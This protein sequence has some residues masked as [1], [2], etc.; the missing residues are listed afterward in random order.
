MAAERADRPLVGAVGSRKR[1]R[2]AALRGPALQRDSEKR[3]P[4][5]PPLLCPRHPRDS[6]SPWGGVSVSRLRRLSGGARG[7]KRC[8]RGAR[9]SGLGHPAGSPADALCLSRPPCTGIGRLGQRLAQKSGV[10]SVTA[11]PWRGDG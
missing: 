10:R 11:K 5:S 1:R 9:A 7:E 3:M 4:A 8:L 2:G 6:R